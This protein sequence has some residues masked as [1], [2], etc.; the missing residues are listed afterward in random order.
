MTNG[1]RLIHL[2]RDLQR[3][4]NA[5]DDLLLLLL[6]HAEAAI[7]IEGV[8]EPDPSDR[9]EMAL[10]D[11]CV[12]EYAAYLFRKRDAS[13][14]GGKNSETGMPRFLRL[15]INNLLFHQKVGGTE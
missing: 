11:A 14:A 3:T 6:Q 10:Y 1:E 9:V 7:N 12:I 8:K 15:Q 2:K 4:T 5:Q 13:T